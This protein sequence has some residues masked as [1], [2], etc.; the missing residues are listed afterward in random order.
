MTEPCGIDVLLGLHM[1]VRVNFHKEKPVIFLSVMTMYSARTQ[2]RP[3]R[4]H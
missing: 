1:G 2:E 4:T 3:M